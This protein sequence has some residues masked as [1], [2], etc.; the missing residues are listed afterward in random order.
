MLWTLN[1]LF[2]VYHN[3]HVN[4][5]IIAADPG[6]LVARPDLNP[7]PQTFAPDFRRRKRE[8]ISARGIQ[9]GAGLHDSR[10]WLNF[11]AIDLR[12]D[13]KGFEGFV[14]DTRG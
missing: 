9:S 8:G 6:V 10:C 14:L 11:T 5:T 12:C 2:G 3:T 1:P 7:H 13:D 4:F